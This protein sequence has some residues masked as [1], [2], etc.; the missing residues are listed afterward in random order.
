MAAGHIA[1]IAFPRLTDLPL[2]LL[3]CSVFLAPVVKIKSLHT[4]EC[5]E[6]NAP[7]IVLIPEILK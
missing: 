1:E 2:Q 6:R 4:K 3:P 7:D 5:I